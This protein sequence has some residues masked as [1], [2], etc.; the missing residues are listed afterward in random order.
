MNA[1]RHQRLMRIIGEALECEAG[2]RDSLLA[3]RC[4]GDPSLRSEAERLLAREMAAEDFLENSIVAAAGDASAGAAEP[5]VGRQV[6]PY[7]IAQPI[8]RGGMGTV[9]LAM[10][11]DGEFRQRVAVK[12]INRGMDT[13]LI[14]R[15]FRAE[16]QIL[17][18]LEHVNIAR[19]LDGGTTDDGLPYLVM[20]YVEGVPVDIYVRSRGL[21]TADRLHLFRGVCDA[22]IY[23]HRKGVI[24][25]DLKPSN[26]LVTPEG[27]PKL[28]D[29]GI[30][31]LLRLDAS[32]PG[33]EATTLSARL[34]T[35]E[36]ASPEQ[37]RGETGTEASDVY[38]LGAVLYELLTER[39]AHL[40]R[41]RLPE[42]VSKVVAEVRPVRPS[43]AVLGAAAE[44]G[45]GY[46]G[47]PGDEER[48]RLQRR[49]K[50]ELDNIILTALRPE[51]G[52]RY[53]T[54]ADFSEDVRRHLEGLPVVARKD[55]VT[56]RA[57][58][59]FGRH[60]SFA[61]T[62]AVVAVMCLL[63]G[64]YLGS[65]TRRPN[66]K[67][68][69]A[70][71][72]FDSTGSEAESEHISEGVTASLA[73][74]LSG[75]PRLVIARRGQLPGAGGATFDSQAVG[76]ALGVETLLTGS[77]SFHGESLTIR[78]D[79]IDAAS[80]QTIWS[81]RYSGR[82][83]DILA[84]E[85]EMAEDVA[86]ELGLSPEDGVRA[87]PR[88]GTEDAE[89]YL[90]Y[91]KGHQ[92][93]SRRTYLAIKQGIDYFQRA[94]EKDPDYA[95]AYTGLANSYFLL[96]VWGKNV[97]GEMFQQSRSAALKALEMEPR[98]AEAHTS[99][100]VVRWLYDWDWAEADR[101]FQLA[102]RYDPHYTTAHHWYGLYLAEMGRFDEAVAAEKHALE[103]DPLS[104][105]VT[106]DLGRVYFYS[107]RYQEAL[108][109]YR[110]AAAM[111]PTFD[112]F[113]VEACYVYEQLGMF[114]EWYGTMDILGR[115]DE[116]GSREAF[117]AGGYKGYLRAQLA[118]YEK[119]AAPRDWSVT[120]YLAEIHA[121]LGDAD[122][123][124]K[125][126]DQAFEARDHK[127]AQ[128]KV[129]PKFDGLRGD[130]RFNQLLRRMNLTP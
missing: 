72:T 67:A 44:A 2:R 45:G 92:L 101:E 114:D 78:A 99:L 91:L 85:R 68:S 27:T 61:T 69:A 57:L 116:A 124:F 7:R 128:L 81:K 83:G 86:R 55:S 127:M 120:Y 4:A 82:P 14:L 106:A 26:I 66:L 117:R 122:Q 65:S 73:R 84:L 76:Q 41:S 51:P 22:V 98:L 111:N 11:A 39:R 63:L 104:L 112:A 90:L 15:R 93:W 75:L 77:V 5:L 113:H 16:R 62:V 35:P 17:A 119:P 97:P 21:S 31:K 130:L 46:S 36:Y 70:V 60:R 50:G 80:A 96:G 49:L 64:T 38:S 32:L 129:N 48:T 13:D 42:E 20:E 29:F 108:E 54:V 107:R 71:I 74:S 105:Y 115:F 102:I 9:Y 94:I 19:L 103:L 88:R 12:V 3:E 6:G 30:A 52:R 125:L 87:G 109:Q 18:D 100:A 79:I 37:L 23:A 40:L 1:E 58:K 24:H 28:L 47:G 56:Y 123:A 8:G 59:F 33:T 53:A 95:L 126:L 10:R 43:D 25:R 89:A 110:K 34:L 121:T 118:S